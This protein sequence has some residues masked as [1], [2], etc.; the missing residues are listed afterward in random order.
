[1]LQ[2]G[3][4]AILSTFIKLPFAIKTFVLSILSCRLHRYCRDEAH[5]ALSTQVLLYVQ[6]KLSPQQAQT[7]VCGIP[8]LIYPQ[9]N[10]DHCQSDFHKNIL[11]SSELLV[12]LPLHQQVTITSIHGFSL[13]DPKAPVKY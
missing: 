5:I 1:M 13:R 10:E 9:R 2:G 3:H 4:S 11:S 12:M 7:T 6:Y 8:E